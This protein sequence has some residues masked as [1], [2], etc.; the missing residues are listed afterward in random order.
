MMW[1]NQKLPEAQTHVMPI[2]AGIH[3]RGKHCSL[4]SHSQES[5]GITPDSLI[6]QTMWQCSRDPTSSVVVVSP[7]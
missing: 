6:E 7:F 4:A 2:E 5:L 3:A 1:R